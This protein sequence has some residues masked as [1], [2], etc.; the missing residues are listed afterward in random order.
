MLHTAA[1]QLPDEE[2]LTG[3]IHHIATLQGSN[4][5]TE[6]API[7]PQIETAVRQGIEIPLHTTPAAAVHPQLSIQTTMGTQQEEINVATGQSGQEAQRINVITSPAN[8]ALKGNPPPIFTG[9]VAMTKVDDFE[10]SAI[11]N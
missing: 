8:G 7:L 2:I 10:K 1:Q 5:F 3:G 9:S 11:E 4:L 6:Q